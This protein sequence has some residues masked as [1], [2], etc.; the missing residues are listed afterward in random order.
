MFAGERGALANGS[1][2]CERVSVE[3]PEPIVADVREPP[4]PN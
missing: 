4:L 3:L 2:I 1:I